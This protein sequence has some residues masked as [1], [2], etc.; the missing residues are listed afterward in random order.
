MIKMFRQIA[1]QLWVWSLRHEALSHIVNCFA[2]VWEF[3]SLHYIH[4][5]DSITQ[6]DISFTARILTVSLEI[7]FKLTHPALASSTSTQPGIS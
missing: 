5:F 1:P 4:P 2:A 6:L 3:A 7:S